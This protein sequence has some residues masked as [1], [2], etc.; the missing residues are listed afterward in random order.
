MM[1]GECP[2][3]AAYA[4]KDPAELLSRLTRVS[5]GTGK[6][7]GDLFVEHMSFHHL[8]GHPE[9]VRDAVS[10]FASNGQMVNGCSECHAHI[11][12]EG[13]DL[14]VAVQRGSDIFGISPEQIFSSYLKVY[15]NREHAT[16]DA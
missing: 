12:S 14:M 2:E 4:R 15:H 7:V 1:I 16:A 10:A 9:S 8:L 6:T 5:R 11:L 3:C 13:D